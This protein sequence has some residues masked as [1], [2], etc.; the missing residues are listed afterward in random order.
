[1]GWE[2]RSE[3]N[4]DEKLLDKYPTAE[5][6]QLLGTT[7]RRTIREDKKRIHFFAHDNIEAKVPQEQQLTARYLAAAF[8][9]ANNRYLGRTVRDDERIWV[10]W[11][12]TRR[13]DYTTVGAEYNPGQKH[14]HQIIIRKD[15]RETTDLLL[16]CFDA[17]TR[18]AVHYD[19]QWE[20]G[21][22]PWLSA[23]RVLGAIT[24]VIDYG[25][26]S[27]LTPKKPFQLDPFVNDFHFAKGE[28]GTGVAKKILPL[29]EHQ[30]YKRRIQLQWLARV[31]IREIGDMKSLEKIK[32][33][34]NL[35]LPTEKRGKHPER[36]RIRHQGKIMY[37]EPRSIEPPTLGIEQFYGK[38][39]DVHF[40]KSIDEIRR[41][42]IRRAPYVPNDQVTFNGR[43]YERFAS[44]LDYVVLKLLTTPVGELK[45]SMERA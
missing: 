15:G 6:S 33:T 45:A 2:I 3:K 42:L 24:E 26:Y 4:W 27:S 37:V 21:R 1:M 17:E 12:K 14:Q 30:Q 44:Q 5:L 18:H 35:L 9:F 19:M 28:D 11:G 32:E 22:N 31:P 7:F 43:K 29:L 40:L 36:H 10:E 8:Y 13:G 23:D 20:L 39:H 34:M 25:G 41:E 38:L 16:F